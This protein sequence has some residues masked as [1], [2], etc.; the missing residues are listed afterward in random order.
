MLPALLSLRNIVI[1]QA[2][3]WLLSLLQNAYYW[4]RLPERVATH[5]NGTGQADGWMHRDQATLMMIGFQTIMPILFIGIAYMIYFIP[6]NLI[7]IP[8]RE[9]WLSG[10]RREASLAFVARSTAA[11]SLAISA[12]FLGINQLTFQANTSDGRLNPWA[13]WT[14]LVCFLG[15]TALWILGLLLRF[16]I[17]K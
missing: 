11:F 3:L 6:A 16:R 14:L 12:F 13:F 4:Q 9:F 17:P 15:F 1:A 5:F 10:D 7:N 8:H 2:A